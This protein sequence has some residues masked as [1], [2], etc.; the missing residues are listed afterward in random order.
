MKI[1]I[2]ED[3]GANDTEAETSVICTRKDCMYAL[4]L[5]Y[6]EDIMCGYYDRTGHLRSNICPPGEKCT[7]YRRAPRRRRAELGLCLQWKMLNK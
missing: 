3:A 1:M 6:D 2:S 4:P 7:V 5:F